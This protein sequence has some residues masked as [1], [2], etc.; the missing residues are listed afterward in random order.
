MTSESKTAPTQGG[1]VKLLAALFLA[2]LLAGLAVRFHAAGQASSIYGPTHVT[3]GSRDVF[4][5]FSNELHRFSEQGEWLGSVTIESLGVRESPIDLVALAD[6]RLVIAEQRPARIRVCDPGN[7]SCELLG[8]GPLAELERQ[9]KVL[10]SRS[11]S[12]WWV[13]D[14]PGDTL[15]RLEPESGNLET[16]LAPGTLAG[17][18]GLAYD[19]D[20]RLWVADTDHRRIVELLP[21]PEGGLVT[22][23]EHSAMNALTVGNRH[24][25]MMLEWSGDG[26][27]WVVQAASFAEASADLVLYHPEKGASSVVPLPRGAYP[28]DLAAAGSGFLVSDMEQFRVYRIDTASR[29]V[30]EFGDNA[31]KGRLNEAR[32][33]RTAYERLGTVSLAVTVIGAV[34]LIVAAIRLT[35]RGQRWSQVPPALDLAARAEYPGGAR[36]I[37]WL[38]RNTRM[39]WLTGGLEKAFYV[40][41]GLLCLVSFLLYSWSCGRVSGSSEGVSE[42]DQLGLLLL[43]VCLATA[44]FIPM[45]H[46]AGGALRRRLGADGERIHLEFE[47]GRRVAVAPERLAWNDRAIFYG[48]HTFP[49]QTGRKNRLYAEGEVQTWLAPM[50]GPAQKLSEWQAMRHQWRHRDR[51]LF[52]TL[53]AVLCLLLI[54]VLVEFVS[55]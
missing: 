21:S 1:T 4:L 12:H 14:A 25:P 15:L 17:P 33:R 23:R 55:A 3:A 5:L 8:E 29:V 37:H 10:P 2:L 20:G 42:A 36:G 39:R 16:V 47:N 43:L 11:G 27:F 48:P 9:Y 31:F 32:S 18:N 28:T 6:G 7:W 26:H 51:V 13:T 49:M 46:F 50:L 45:I 22:G 40:L 41:L 54:L 44:T 19:G 53:G 34:L 30:E 35:P 38:E 24:Y 52:A